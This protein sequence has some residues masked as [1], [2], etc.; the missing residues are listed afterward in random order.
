M[1]TVLTNLKAKFGVDT[2]DFKKGL[3][4]GENATADFKEAAGSQLEKFASMFGLDMGNVSSAIGTANKSL[5][6]L[7]Q[8]FK[9]AAVSSNVLSVALKVLKFAITA[10]GIGAIIVALGTLIAYFQK[11]GEG[12][13]KFAKIL[14]QIKGVV[15]DVIDRLAVFGKGLWQLMTGHFKEGWETMRGA[16]KGMGAEMKETWTEMGKLADREDA[17]EDREIALINSL[18]ERKAKSAELR[19]MAKEETD[20]NHKKLELLKQAE[21]LTKSVYADQVSVERERLAIMKEKLRLQ[22]SDPTD[23][24]R[25]EIAEQEAKINGLLREQSMELK[26][27]LK[28]KNSVLEVEKKLFGQMNSYSNLKMPEFSNVKWA[29]NLKRSMNELQ[30]TFIQTKESANLFF[31]VFD[32]VAIDATNTLNESLTSLAEGFGEVLGSLMTGNAGF[33]DFGK[34]IAGVFADMAINVGKIAI[35]AGM[36][37]LG[38]KKALMSLNPY[39]AIAAGVALV[40]LG[41]AIKGSLKNAAGGVASGTGGEGAGFTYDTRASKQQAVQVNIN[42]KLV[43]Q[44]KDLVYVFDQESNR[45]YATTGN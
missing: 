11:T 37:V 3:K 25:R 27:M 33:Q 29:E 39:V 18:E 28:E 34:M 36:A 4:D 15:N 21:A 22:S 31:E 8:S 2:S 40:A 19:R 38:I 20:D 14:L 23:D 43:A 24:Q 1:G 45:R 13:D 5:S 44:G 32:E 12:S 26:A 9:G 10:T 35:G 17:L 6:F 7:A 42:G 41:T 16:F 30:H